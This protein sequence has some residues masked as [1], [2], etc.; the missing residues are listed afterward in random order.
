MERPAH[1]YVAQHMICVQYGGF[2]P[3]PQEAPKRKPGEK[4]IGEM[5][6][7]KAR[8][9][10]RK[11]AVTGFTVV[12]VL[13]AVGIMTMITL[14]YTVNF[15]NFQQGITVQSDADTIASRIRQMQVWALTGELINGSRPDGGYGL[16]IPSPCIS[17][18]C[19]YTVFANTCT[20]TS[21]VYDNGCDTVIASENLNA[22]VNVSATS[23][24]GALTLI[25]LP[26]TAQVYSNA[27]QSQ[28]AIITLAHRVQSQYTKSIT[29]DGV[30]GQVN[31]Q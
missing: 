16:Y 29:V 24:A 15:K 20:P 10:G 14:L 26:P 17:G 28:S 9:H 1:H 8:G 13:V 5:R 12:E 30:S 6:S 22:Q 27:V 21:Y 23:P 11:A 18:T 2:T 4:Y 19:A 25:L 7:A 3:L 31:V